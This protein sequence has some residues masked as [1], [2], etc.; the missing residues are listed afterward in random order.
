MPLFKSGSTTTYATDVK[1]VVGSTTRNA[2][3]NWMATRPTPMARCRTAAS[4][5]TQ[6]DYAT[7]PFTGYTQGP[8]YYGKT[9]FIWPPDPRQ[10]LT[11][12]NS[13]NQIK[14]FLMDF[15]YTASD[16][17]STS[18]TTTL[19]AS[20]TSSQT[21][22]TVDFLL[23]FSKWLVSNSYRFGN[24]LGELG[25]RND[26]DSATRSEWDDG[27]NTLV[28]YHCR[29]VTG[30]PL[31]GIYNVTYHHEQPNWPWPNDGGSTLSTYLT[32]QVYAPASKTKLTNLAAQ[33]QKI[34]RLYS[35]NYVVDNLGTFLCGL[36][37]A[38][39]RHV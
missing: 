8:G 6:A 33:Y 32:S 21:S 19:T 1:D 37:D 38:V 26:L 30:P 3:G 4:S 39:L 9:F 16:F 11:T 28:K 5:W 34:M 2:S 20:I 7:A 36:A 17:S 23:T 29:A 27:R 22:L 18:V 12:A 13:P 31:S 35:W 15:G 14:Q 24:H 10:P 25:F